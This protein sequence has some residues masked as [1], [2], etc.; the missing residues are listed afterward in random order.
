[1]RA[2]RW[3][4]GLIVFFA[5]VVIAVVLIGALADEASVT[6]Y[7]HDGDAYRDAY[8]YTA[9]IDVY[10]RGLD[11]HPSSPTLLLRLCDVSLRR[12][13]VEQ[14][15]SYAN[16]VTGASPSDRAEC[17]ARIADAQQRPDQAAA[18]WSII[19]NAR[20]ADRDAYTHLIESRI[21]A[22]DWPD[23]IDA[24]QMLLDTG[25]TSALFYLGAL[26]VLDDP[27]RAR[28]YL[29]DD[30]SDIALRLVAALD[31]PFS[32][33]NPAYRAV[34][35]GRVF[36]DEGELMLAWRAYAAATALNP[37]YSDGFAYLGITTDRLGDTALAE[38]YLE[39][40][41]TL[42]SDSPV[43]LY[44]R[45][46]YFSRHDRLVAARV[47]LERAAA[48][49]P[50]N[51]SIA[52]ALSHVLTEQGEYAAA[53]D[54]LAHALELEPDNITWLMAQ[55]ELHIGHLIDVDT[56]GIP[57]ARRVIELDPDHAEAHSWLGWGLHL[58][59]EDG[60]AE[61]ELLR[62]LQLDPASARARL[63][64]GKFLIDAA[65]FEAGR[66]ELQRALDLDA[67]GEVG[68]RAKQ[69]LGEPP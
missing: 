15:N 36:L 8:L 6:R 17:L 9:A 62:A 37:E 28:Q 22:R 39:R 68:A 13:D 25:D 35:L 69:L 24:A 31:H 52:F 59:G 44:L 58:I 61:Q 60:E 41:H 29:L 19:V 18:Q 16:Q 46:V 34:A 57:A 40:A 51:T 49:E 10:Q 14:A 53:R 50:D 38:A 7:V 3:Q 48:F 4:T 56:A 66:T 1:M 65:R 2:M 43:V 47:D 55:V 12:G 20:T 23:A 45:G 54:L 63:H 33:I 27:S 64:F 42:A 32:A 30:G 67:Y 21:A 26:N 5:F 11:A